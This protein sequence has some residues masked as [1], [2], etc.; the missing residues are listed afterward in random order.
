[1]DRLQLNNVTKAL[2]MY[3]DDIVEL[4]KQRL[5]QGRKIASGNLINEMNSYVEEEDDKAFLYV[6][7][8][9]YARYVD[10]GR[11]PN[12]KW[13]PKK[14]IDDWM[15]QKGIR[16]RNMTK[17]QLSFLIRR[18]IGIRGIAAFPFLDIWDMH[19]EELEELIEDAAIEDVEKVINEYIKDF[20]KKNI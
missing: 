2:K 18:K 17:D 6:D 4:M 14:P 20:N 16:A 7:I 9:S 8:P 12:S 10:E 11:K 5:Q 13:P 3:G 19:V 1:M 15:T